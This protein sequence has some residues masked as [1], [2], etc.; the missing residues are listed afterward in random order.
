VRIY[1]YQPTT[2]HAKT[3][4]VDGVWSA[5]ATMNFDNR[6]LAYN[7]EVALVTWDAGTGAT[8]DS[9]FFDDL[10]FAQEIRLDAFRRR[11][12]TTRLLERGAGLVAGLL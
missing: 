10:R 6:S 7:D 4:V 12:W 2:I 9:L 1:E 8:L 3:F 5:V 11:P